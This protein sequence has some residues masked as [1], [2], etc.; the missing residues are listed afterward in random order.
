MEK[1]TKVVAASLAHWSKGNSTTYGP[2]LWPETPS[3]E[4]FN[5]HACLPQQSTLNSLMLTGCNERERN[6]SHDLCGTALLRIEVGFCG[7]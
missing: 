6:R 7:V 5:S 4:F 2:N 3:Q 1:G